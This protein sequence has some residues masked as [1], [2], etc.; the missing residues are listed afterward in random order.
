[1]LFRSFPTLNLKIPP[2]FNVKPGIYA[3]WVW[4]ENR[5]YLGA[6]H[7]GPLPVFFDPTP[8]LEVFVIDY[9]PNVPVTAITFE[10]VTYLRPIRNFPNPVALAHRISLDVDK[11]RAMLN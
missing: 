1:M 4:I 5:Q 9:K 2:R 3:G 7:F 8:H 11:T 10:L 6:F